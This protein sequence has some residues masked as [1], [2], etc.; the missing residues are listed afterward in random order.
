MLVSVELGSQSAM[1]T[2][3]LPGFDAFCRILLDLDSIHRGKLYS[4][5]WLK[6]RASRGCT[7]PV[8]HC[9]MAIIALNRDYEMIIT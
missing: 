4:G 9:A 5:I 7:A 6:S 8:F 2:T 3:Q 1:T